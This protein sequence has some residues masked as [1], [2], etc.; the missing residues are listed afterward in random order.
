MSWAP[1]TVDAQGVVWSPDGRWL[2]VWESPALGHKVIFYT[3]DG[4]MFKVWTGPANPALE[5]KDYALGAGVKLV[6]F[7]ADAR[8]LAIGDCSKS[9]STF[10]MM[11]ATEGPRL[12]HPNSIAP[13]DTLQVSIA[14]FSPSQYRRFC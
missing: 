5:D 10:N 3:A 8:V 12:K 1:D 9:I 6:R 13:R 7:S 2:V 11:S 14:F 4:H